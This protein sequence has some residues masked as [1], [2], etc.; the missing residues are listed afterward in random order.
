MSQLDP[1]VSY[2]LLDYQIMQNVYETLLWYN[3]SNSTDVIPW[4][5][6]NY[7]VSADQKTYSFTLRSGISFADGEPLNSTAVYFSLNRLLIN[8]GSYSVG[9][10]G[11]AAWIIQQ[12]LNSSLSSAL[13]GCSLNY[14][15]TYVSNVLAE[16][17]VQITGPLTF[18]LH[19]QNPSA[20]L[21]FLLA[22][23][24]AAI[25]APGFVMQHDLALWSQSSN[26]Y[27]LPYPTLSGNETQMSNEYFADWAST[28][29]TGTTPNGCATTYLDV[30][31]QGSTA[32]TG[33]Y[34]VAS[35]NPT[36]GVETLQANSHY[37]GSPNKLTPTFQTIV[38]KYVPSLS[39]RELDLTSA[40]ASGQA[41]SVD[42]PNSNLYDVA[43]RNAWLGNNQ[44]VSVL[45]GV[46][47]YGPYSCR[48][49][50]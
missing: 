6:Q 22:G 25:V 3:G 39:T 34:T 31:Q 32:G 50:L 18:E 14:N 37:W 49:L 36:T 4:L 35:A 28:C 7:T 9:H 33:P 10:G 21:P 13:C 20:S 23:E 24:W 2:G 46:S 8:D 1:G 38:V 27:T 48:A 15:S 43:N 16:N 47:I 19:L 40:A 45:Q 30:S 44:L 29:N 42:I 5:V 41:M 17:F 26:G 11:G 12:L